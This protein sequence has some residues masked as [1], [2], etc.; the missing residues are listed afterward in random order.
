MAL[1][2]AL[3]L[4]PLLVT[5]WDQLMADL[6]CGRVPQLGPGIGRARARAGEPLVRFLGAAH[7]LGVQA[8]LALAAARVSVRLATGAAPFGDEL[9]CPTRDLGDAV[10]AASVVCIC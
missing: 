9:L 8:L 7:H 1:G 10:C 3:T 2:L 5:I 4:E 6:R